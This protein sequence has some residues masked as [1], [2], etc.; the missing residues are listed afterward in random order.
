MK[1]RYTHD[2]DKCQWLGSI[3]YPAPHFT[4]ERGTYH[5]MRNAD[6]Y[7]C[8]SG[9]SHLDTSVIARFSSRGSDYASSPVALMPRREP[10][11]DMKGRLGY[12]TSGP[13]LNTAYDFAKVQGLIK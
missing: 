2:C 12:S 5:V 6:L 7:V 9:T 4:E 10:I 8:I 13:A 1:P 11:P 3:T